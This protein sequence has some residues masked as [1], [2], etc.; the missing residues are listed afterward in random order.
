[1]SIRSTGISKHEKHAKRVQ[2]I[3]K[4]ADDQGPLLFTRQQVAKMLN[5][6]PMTVQRMSQDGRLRSVKLMPDVEN[7]R[8]YIRASDVYALIEKMFGTS[9]ADD[10]R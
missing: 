1:M 6:S 10:A 7:A 8:V 9:E 3:V 4:P 2:R 5:V